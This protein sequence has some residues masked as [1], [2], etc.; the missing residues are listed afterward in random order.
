MS[1]LT[2]RS[3]REELLSL[4]HPADAL[5][6]PIPGFPSH[7]AVVAW[8][9]TKDQRAIVDAALETLRTDEWAQQYAAMALL[10]ELGVPTEGQGY[11]DAFRWIVSLGEQPDVIEPEVK[12]LD[13]SVPTAD[14]E[15]LEGLLAQL[16]IGPPSRELEAWEID[17]RQLVARTMNNLDDRSKIVLVLHYFERLTYDEI[18]QILNLAGQDVESVARSALHALR[19]RLDPRT[20]QRVRSYVEDA[21]DAVPLDT[22]ALAFAALLAA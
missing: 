11:G 21:L 20:R 12:P 10:R 2:T 6:V 7:D 8:A 15:G 18:G 14:T 13:P 22:P 1:T 16:G 3:L 19:G 4:L 5:D 9:R 17:L